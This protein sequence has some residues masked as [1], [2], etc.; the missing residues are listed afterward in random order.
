[1]NSAVQEKC[2]KQGQV[3]NDASHVFDK[4]VI[5]QQTDERADGLTDQQNTLIGKKIEDYLRFLTHAGETR[6]PI[7]VWGQFPKLKLDNS[8]SNET[9]QK[10]LASIF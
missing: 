9:M 5:N 2:E 4:N 3:A 6:F 10:V 1:M 7:F 8:G